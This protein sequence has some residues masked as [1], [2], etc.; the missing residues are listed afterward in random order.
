MSL[1]GNYG[2]SPKNS[3]T[4]T[5]RI[6]MTPRKTR[7]TKQTEEIAIAFAFT[8][9]DAHKRRIENDR[10]KRDIDLATSVG[11]EVGTMREA[12]RRKAREARIWDRGFIIGVFVA[13]ICILVGLYSVSIAEGASRPAPSPHAAAT[14]SLPPHYKQWLNTCHAEQPR[15]GTYA[16]R[17]T[18]AN[19]WWHQTTNYTYVGGC[20]FTALNWS[21]FKRKG[22]PATMNLASP[23]EQLWACERIYNHFAKIG[24]PA[25][26]A[27]VWDANQTIGFHGFAPGK[28]R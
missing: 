26:G 21:Q 8:E 23:L 3:P 16:G 5:G 6:V 1:A 27:S 18:F 13:I 15:P 12:D 25:Y 7:T 22:Q 2:R 4:T 20:G 9:Y 24:G 10:R 17:G 19:I 11:I 28:N 14:M